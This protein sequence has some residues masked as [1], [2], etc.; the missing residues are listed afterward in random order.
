VIGAAAVVL[1]AVVGG[2]FVYIHFI[3]GKA[4]APLTLSSGPATTAAGSTDAPATTAASAASTPPTLG[5]AASSTAASGTAASGA[6]SSGVAGTWNIGSGSVVGYRIKE[7]LFGQSNTAVGRTS[8]ISGSITI[9]ATTVTA[10]HFT[11]DMTKVTSDQSQRDHQF[12]GRIMDTSTYPTATFVLSQ[13]I[14]LGSVP[15]DGTIVTKTALG[16]LTMHGT[17]KSVT[18]TVQARRSGSTISISGSIPI[19]FADY[20]ISN[21]SG[22]PAT[23]SNNGTLEFLLN[24]PHA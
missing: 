20:G 10:G 11:V 1:V 23:T 8:A 16:N 22:G 19:V 14:Q 5:T 2:P 7:T 6:A 21:P 17:T 15:A 9:S 18:F 4:P 3:E 13:P 24:L 12:Q